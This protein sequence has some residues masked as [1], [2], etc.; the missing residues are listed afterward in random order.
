MS[1][2]RAVWGRLRGQLQAFRGHPPACG[3]EAAAYGRC[4]Q[5]ST[6]PGG[7]LTKDLCAQE[8]K[9]LRKSFAAPAQ[10]GRLS[11]WKIGCLTH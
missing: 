7:R 10:K 6:A 11:G 2:N 5:A 1:W 4:V 9:A 8:F 3:A